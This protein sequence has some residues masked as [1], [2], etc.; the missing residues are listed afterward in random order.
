MEDELSDWVWVNESERLRRSTT[1][2]PA[3]SC[4]IFASF[5]DAV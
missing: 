1:D 3:P 5:V 2:R 4:A